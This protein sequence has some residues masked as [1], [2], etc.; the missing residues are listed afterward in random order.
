LDVGCGDGLLVSRL[1]QVCNHA[2]GVEP[3][4]PSAER[5]RQRLGGIMNT[6]VIDVRFEDYEAK[7]GSSDLIVFVL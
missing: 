3:H 1:S 5:A 2:T 6:S 4:A 7:A